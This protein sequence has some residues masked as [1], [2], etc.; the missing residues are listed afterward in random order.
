MR[1]LDWAQTPLGPAPDWPESLGA[2]V[3]VCLGSR[4]P[5]VVFWG[6]ELTFL[7]ND[8]Y[9]PMLGRSKHPSALGRPAREVWP[10]IWDVIG[11]MLEGVLERG[12]ATWSE[13]QLLLLDRNDYTEEAYFTYSFSPIH[14]SKGAIL[15]IFTAVTE[16][17]ERVLSERRLR[18]VAALAERTAGA[19]TVGD[20]IERAHE[21]LATNPDDLPSVE[22]RVGEPGPVAP[23]GAVVLPAGAGA[24]LIAG[25]NPRRALDDR[26]REFF[27]LVAEQLG[28]AIATARGFEVLAE[29]D[30][31]KTEFFSNVSHEFRTPLTLL[32]GPL[33]D[34]LAEPLPEAQRERVETAQRAA[35]RLLRLVNALLDFSRV[36]AGGIEPALEPV[37]L[38]AAATDAAGAFRSLVES[39]GL[40]LALELPDAPV[41][42]EADPELLDKILLNL[43]SNAFK[44]T[45]EGEI[46]V[47]V[48][49]AGELAVADTGVGIPAD[50]IPHLFERFHRVRGTRARS[51]EGSGI[52]LALA[53]ELVL[54]Q[55]GSVGVQSLPGAGSTFTV[56]LPLA[57]AGAA[58][59]RPPHRDD[60]GLLADAGRWVAPA[61]PGGGSG[62]RVLVAEDNADMRAYLVRL[63]GAH[64]AVTATADGAEA[65]ERALEGG[66]DLVLADVMMPG[67]DG[68]ELLRALRAEPGTER[69]PVIMLS[70]RAAEEAAI[71]GLEAGADDYLVKP[72]SANELI[73]RVRSA[74]ELAELREE[75]TRVAEGVAETLQR[76]LLPARLPA[77]PELTLA[78]RYVPAGQGLKVGGDWYDAVPLQDGRVMLAIGDVAGH[79]LRA[80]AIMGQISHALRAYA[81]ED[82][83]PA[84]LMRRLD[85][86]VLAGGLDMTT[87]LCALLDPATGELRWANAGH[88]PPRVLAPDGS[89]R[90][91]DGP[92]SNP[93]GV[94]LGT[95]FREG[96]CVLADGEALVLFTD[97]LV[98]R[99]GPTIDEGIER[100]ARALEADPDPDAV[101][102]AMLG[103]EDPSD[104]VALLIARRSR[105][106]A[107]DAELS[108]PADPHRLRDLRRWLEAWLRGNGLG[109]ERA[110]DLVLAVHEASMNAVEHAYGLAAG[111]I[112]VRVRHEG[113]SVEVRVTD[114]GNWRATGHRP[115]D[116][117]RGESLMRKLVDEVRVERGDGGT[118]VFLRVEL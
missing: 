107:P 57:A 15:G 111:T 73:A 31:A 19:R 7:Y 53:R 44:F 93:L 11:P 115:G 29:L 78:G 76:S 87:C 90:P 116:R 83:G 10:E 33:T 12:D 1:A 104:D 68:F 89:S 13:D 75:R 43:L 40:T 92:L 99:R 102:C 100:L 41:T 69:L 52:G 103:G 16:T 18:T 22:I 86:L 70:A 45:F 64:F 63:L 79:G 47:A 2:A 59:A 98:E 30:R 96:T 49:A 117:G 65:L 37:D 46:R 95:L 94:V 35:L 71:E 62:A 109:G 23:E 24:T 17:T 5:M 56:G 72:F 113:D 67:L 50:E 34:A 8:P 58:A 25:V 26:Y 6:P 27:R 106:A 42:V 66:F 97:G 110:T 55:G 61:T 101:L 14:G 39:V 80:A 85:A 77:L 21:A 51:H 114:R 108:L 91:L 112:E 74:L 105:I 84:D 36:E 32:L 48:T 81:R 54:A 4:F 60:D 9:R 3:S 118:S 88:V 28:G 38:T 82:H 20:V